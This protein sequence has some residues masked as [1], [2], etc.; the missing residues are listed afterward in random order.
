MYYEYI[1]LTNCVPSE[2]ESIYSLKESVQDEKFLLVALVLA[3][4]REQ[5]EK[6]RRVWEQREIR[7]FV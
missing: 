1:T 3:S 4:Y 2:N 6:F 7:E 5:S